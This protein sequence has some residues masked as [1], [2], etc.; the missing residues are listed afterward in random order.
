MQSFRL[1]PDS[2]ISF[3]GKG[4]SLKKIKRKKFKKGSD[5]EQ[6]GML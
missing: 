3:Q 2:L 5:S 6:R 4:L 1:F